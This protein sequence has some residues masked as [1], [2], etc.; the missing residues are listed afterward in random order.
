MR[1][2]GRHPQFVTTNRTTCASHSI[3]LIGLPPVAC[4]PGGD[5][6]FGQVVSGVGGWWWHDG[7]GRGGLRFGRSR[8]GR[9]SERQQR[10]GR[11]WRLGCRGRRQDSQRGSWEWRCLRESRG[12][13]GCSRRGRRWQR[14]RRWRVGR[15]RRLFRRGWRGSLCRRPQRSLLSGGGVLL[16]HRMQGVGQVLH[17]R[18]LVLK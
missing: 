12:R 2:Q 3:G 15:R 7:A 18:G 5:D 1:R 11:R 10:D 4:D 13:G 16:D 6:A 8:R 14:G 9:R 17:G